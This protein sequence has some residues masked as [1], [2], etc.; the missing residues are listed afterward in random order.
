MHWRLCSKKCCAQS[1]AR[2][3]VITHDHFLGSREVMYKADLTQQLIDHAAFLRERWQALLQVSVASPGRHH[4]HHQDTIRIPSSR[5]QWATQLRPQANRTAVHSPLFIH[6]RLF[7]SR[8]YRCICID[9]RK[10][11]RERNA[12]FSDAW[13]FETE[14]LAGHVLALPGNTPRRPAYSLSDVR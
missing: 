8:V 5:D 11:S 6:Q 14:E 4:T 3:A 9:Q 2:Y 7:L 10:P 1:E 12:S 13:L